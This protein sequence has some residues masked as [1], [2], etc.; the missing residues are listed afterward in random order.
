M[1]L[2]N[3]K[4]AKPISP[5]QRWT[6]RRNWEKNQL[7]YFHREL[8]FRLNARWMESQLR[9]QTQTNDEIEKLRRITLLMEDILN[10]WKEN[11]I[12]SRLSINFS[13]YK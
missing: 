12:K 7:N 6:R 1:R 9:S 4:L 13:N 5:L 3:R 2:Y 8:T 11:S 10:N